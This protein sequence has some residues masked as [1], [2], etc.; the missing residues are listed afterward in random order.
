MLFG[1]WNPTSPYLS[2][3]PDGAIRFIEAGPEACPSHFGRD[4]CSALC[5][6]RWLLGTRIPARAV[7]L[8]HFASRPAIR[9][10]SDW[11][12]WRSRW[13]GRSDVDVTRGLRNMRLG[14]SVGATE[15]LW[16]QHVARVGRFHRR[17]QLHL[18]NYS[19]VR[20]RRAQ[21]VAPHGPHN[22]GVRRR[23]GSRSASE[24]CRASTEWPLLAS[25]ETAKMM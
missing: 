24:M 1:D 18:A 5:F 21:E 13:V 2:T 8:A 4:G 14:A 6:S 11:A 25:R 3:P 12:A 22:R 19:G 15:A 9:R 23:A 7:V 10:F 20:H 17:R 16:P